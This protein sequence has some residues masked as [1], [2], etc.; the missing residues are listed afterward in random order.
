VISTVL[1]VAGGIVAIG[2]VVGIVLG[3]VRWLRPPPA[4]RF[5]FTRGGIVGGGGNVTQ[6]WPEIREPRRRAAR[7]YVPDPARTAVRQRSDQGSVG[8]RPGCGPAGR[9][10]TTASAGTGGAGYLA[11]IAAGPQN[12]AQEAGSSRRVALAPRRG[13]EVAP[14]VWGTEDAVRAAS[15][16]PAARDRGV[17]GRCEARMPRGR[18]KRRDS[19]QAA[20]P[21]RLAASP[22][23]RVTRHR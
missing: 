23:A 2:A 8:T 15:P 3:V 7:Q 17:A 18:A 5:T 14:P 10:L 11:R 13:A 20:T 4:P 9:R 16:A 22:R 19:R 1:Q 21:R 6:L 12:A